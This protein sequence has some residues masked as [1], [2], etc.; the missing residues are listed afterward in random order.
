MDHTARRWSLQSSDDESESRGMALPTGVG[1]RGPMDTAG[2]AGASVAVEQSAGVGTGSVP[3][4]RPLVRS[5]TPE[6]CAIGAHAQALHNRTARGLADCGGSGTG[7]T[8]P[9]LPDRSHSPY[10]AADSK[11]FR[12]PVVDYR[13]RAE[14]FHNH[15]PPTRTVQDGWDTPTMNSTPSSAQ[16]TP[17]VE[18]AQQMENAS[19]R[20]TDRT[21]SQV[22]FTTQGDSA[23]EAAMRRELQKL[24]ATAP[25]E[26][27]A[28]R[29]NAAARKP[30]RD[31]DSQ[32]MLTSVDGARWG[33]PVV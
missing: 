22:K 16:P 24:V 2:G 15:R 14:Q 33:L 32:W 31:G 20:R 1:Q 21:N 23:V 4:A 19:L 5:P 18:L 10:R 13:E 8:P 27:R 3:L 30:S 11:A 12:P 7:G 28:V 9:P 29:P 26:Q 6:E 17:D 25:E